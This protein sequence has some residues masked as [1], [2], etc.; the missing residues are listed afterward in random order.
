MKQVI[1][2]PDYVK[3]VNGAGRTRP[4]NVLIA[5]Q[6]QELGTLA[7]MSQI[8]KGTQ[9]PKRIDPSYQQVRGDPI[10]TGRSNVESLEDDEAR[11]LKNNIMGSNKKILALDA[12]NRGFI[13]K[14]TNPNS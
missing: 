7:R 12:Q 14:A 4:S 5:P 3:G 10:F 13:K 1:T 9:T 8:L 2:S 11:G 6:T